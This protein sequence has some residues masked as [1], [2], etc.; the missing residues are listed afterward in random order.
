MKAQDLV[1]GIIEQL[2]RDSSAK[3]NFLFPAGARIEILAQDGQFLG[4]AAN[5]YNTDSLFNIYGLYGS[6]YSATSIFNPYGNYGSQYAQL[7]PFNRYT[8]TPP[9]I[10]VNGI[11]KALLTMNKHLPDAIP[12]DAFLFITSKYNG[13]SEERLSEM[14]LEISDR[15]N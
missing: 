3:Y 6:K 5:V 9:K 15:L 8:Q 4:S 12:V 2:Y 11:E 14:M 10:Y 1:K 13:V 7:S